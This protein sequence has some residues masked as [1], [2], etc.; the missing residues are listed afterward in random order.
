M[1][2]FMKSLILREYITFYN[3]RLTP[4]SPL[5]SLKILN[6]FSWE[7][8]LFQRK[9]E[10]I[11]ELLTITIPNSNRWKELNLLIVYFYE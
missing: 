1:I 4:V 5:M 10:R 11:S 8:V 7:T 9:K 3:V 2:I 6:I